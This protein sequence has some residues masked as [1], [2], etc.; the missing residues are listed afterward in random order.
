MFSR[1]NKSRNVRI[2]CSLELVGGMI[3]RGYTKDLSSK[4]L[5]MESQGFSL[6]GRTPPQSGDMGNL[7]LYFRRGRLIDSI[8]V[9]S[10]ILNVVANGVGISTRFSDLNQK[11][12]RI[13]EHIL[14]TGSDII[15]GDLQ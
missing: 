3:M 5:F 11:E 14:T 15:P 8:Q 1:R 10:R 13:I 6:Q 2:R 7:R 12:R 9:R 4:G